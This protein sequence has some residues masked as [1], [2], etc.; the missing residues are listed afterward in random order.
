MIQ[1]GKLKVG[2]TSG[3]A[4]VD[5]S[6]DTREDLIVAAY[7]VKP[8]QVNG[9]A[10]IKMDRFDIQAKLPDSATSGTGAADAAEGARRAFPA[11]RTQRAT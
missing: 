6:V 3:K 2:I 4:R 11:N 1:A 9:P 10:W 5:I 7:R 8:Y